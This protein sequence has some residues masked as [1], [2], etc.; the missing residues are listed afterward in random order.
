MPGLTARTINEL[1]DSYGQS[2]FRAGKAPRIWAPRCR[3]RRGHPVLFSWSLAHEVAQ[4]AAGEGLNALVARHEVE[5]F[6]SGSDSI[7]E[8]LDTPEDYERLRARYGL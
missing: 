3:G 7:L 8:D 1:I 4:L 6:E 2:L 5:D